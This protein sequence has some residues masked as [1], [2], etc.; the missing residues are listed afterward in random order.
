MQTISLLFLLNLHIVIMFS[1]RSCIFLLPA[2]VALFAVACQEPSYING[3][4]DNL[5]NQ[6][7]IIPIPDPEPTPAP[8][9][10]AVPVGA[11]N[12]YQVRDTCAKLAN[13]AVS[14]QK[15]YIYG[16]VKSFNESKHL[17]GIQG[18]GNAFFY[19]TATDDPNAQKDFYAYQC[20]GKLGAKMPDAAV[21]QEGDFVVI[22][23]YVT[24]YSGT[25]YETTSGACIVSSTNPNFNNAFYDFKGCPEPDAA[26]G[27]ISVT[28]AEAICRGLENKATTSETYD[29]IGVVNSIDD[30][31]STTYGNATFRITDGKSF[32]IAYRCKGMNGTKFTNANQVQLGD[33]VVVTGKLQ[34]YNYTPEV[35]GGYLSDSTNPNL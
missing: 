30:A 8:E 17:D 18:Y 23:A 20:M 14:E 13:G 6:D 10:I 5:F 27:Q 3:P 34:N 28:E 31:V 22:S 26:A 9:G 35:S 16:W 25:T 21:I 15:Y 7:S 33:T 2:F 11:L 29:I 19:M 32:L 24:N 4:G 1:N 12:V